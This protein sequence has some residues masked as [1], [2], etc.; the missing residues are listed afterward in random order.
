[1]RVAHKPFVI[2]FMCENRSLHSQGNDET[3][4]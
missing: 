3:G 2:V 1:M 4:P